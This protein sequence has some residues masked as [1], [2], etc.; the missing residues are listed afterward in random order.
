MELA[1]DD[2]QR[3]QYEI[4]SG[5]GH[6]L[7]GHYCALGVSVPLAIVLSTAHSSSD[8]DSL[9]LGTMCRLAMYDRGGYTHHV[10]AAVSYTHLDVYKRQ[11]P[12]AL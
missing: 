10:L 1:C 4:C 2:G 8:A 3:A 12:T 9:F 7:W 11:V 5:L 6:F